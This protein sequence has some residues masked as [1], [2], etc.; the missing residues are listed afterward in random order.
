MDSSE[1]D[2]STG[3]RPEFKFYDENLRMLTWYAD[4][5]VAAVQRAGARSL[6]SLGIG[7]QVVSRTILGRLGGSLGEYTIVEGSAA[8]IAEFRAQTPIPAS[9][10]LE[11]ALFEQFEAPHPIDAIEMG[12]VLEHVDDPRL[13]VSR[14]ASFLRPGGVLVI[15]VPNARSLHRLVGYRAGLLDDP[16][17]LSPQDLELGHQRYFDLESIRAVIREAGLRILVTEGIF[18]KCVTTEQLAR[19]GLSPE[20]MDGFFRVAVDYPEISNA[21]YLETTR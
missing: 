9:V 5:L 20:V 6:L 8:R 7:H 10:R 18:L 13:I 3:Y 12:F 2:R 11:N 15:V 16:Y 21:I 14:F 1:L 19:L 17:R 4:R